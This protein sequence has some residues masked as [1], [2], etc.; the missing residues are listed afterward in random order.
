MSSIAMPT[1]STTISAKD[2]RDSLR[3]LALAAPLLLLLL[4]SFGM[5]IVASA[6]ARRL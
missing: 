4:F 6:V 5:P 2:H 1:I 3:S